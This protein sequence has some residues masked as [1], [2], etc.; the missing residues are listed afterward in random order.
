MPFVDTMPVSVVARFPDEF[1]IGGKGGKAVLRAA[2]DKVRE[3]VRR[4]KVGFRVPR[5]VQRPL[6]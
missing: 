5:M 1:L 6:S 2:M 4:K 3:I